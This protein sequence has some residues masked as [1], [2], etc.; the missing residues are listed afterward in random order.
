MKLPQGFQEKMIQLAVFGYALSY[1]K[2]S[3]CA[4]EQMVIDWYR[5]A[6]PSTGNNVCWQI[7]FSSNME[8][9]TDVH[10]MIVDYK[11]CTSALLRILGI[12]GL[13]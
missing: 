1:G 4:K 7:S 6:K 3:K 9:A 8:H 2:K 13:Q 10:N 11:I 5:Y 12:D